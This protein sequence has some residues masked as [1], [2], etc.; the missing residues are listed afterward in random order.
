MHQQTSDIRSMMI[1]AHRTNN[2]ANLVGQ[3]SHAL[4]L[5]QPL[6]DAEFLFHSIM[7][8]Q[9]VARKILQ[10]LIKRDDLKN[11]ICCDCSNPNPQWA[12]LRFSHIQPPLVL[13]PC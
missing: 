12:S 7:T 9:T 3:D 4:P 8:D 10:E 13:V 11:K 5:W 1:V 6:S 2:V